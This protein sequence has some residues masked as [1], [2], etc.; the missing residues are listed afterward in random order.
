MGTPHVAKSGLPGL[1]TVYVM[2][3]RMM[4]WMTS[5]QLQR[6]LAYLIQ[7]KKR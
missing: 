3:R 2:V 5:R 7:Q 4:F 6:C 1:V